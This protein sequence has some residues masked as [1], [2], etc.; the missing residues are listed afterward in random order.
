MTF[1]RSLL[2]SRPWLAPAAIAAIGVSCSIASF[3]VLDDAEEERIASVVE[4][5]TEWRSLDFQH[6]IS[7]AL[8]ALDSTAAFVASQATVDPDDLAKFAASARRAGD[9]VRAIAWAPHVGGADRAAFGSPIL[10]RAGDGTRAPAAPRDHYFPQ[11]AFAGFDGI[12]ADPGVD[13]GQDIA[14]RIAILR[15]IDDGRPRMAGASSPT[16][17]T[18]GAAML[19]AY[20]PIYEAD[21]TPASVTERRAAVRGVVAVL[22]R[23]DDVLAIA[24]RDSPDIRDIVEFRIRDHADG[25]PPVAVAHYDPDARRIVAAPIPA[26]AANP[27]G[28]VVERTVAMLGHDWD[29]E[30]HIA[31]ETIAGLVSLAPEGWMLAGLL[32]TGLLALFVRRQSRRTAAVEAVVAQRTAALARTNAALQVEMRER[33]ESQARYRDLVELSP[34]AIFVLSD[35]RLVYVNSATLR[36]YGASD[37]A[38]LIGRRTLDLVHPDDRDK[39]I[40]RRAAMAAGVH[41]VPPIELRYLRLDGT[42]VEVEAVASALTFD[43]KPAIQAIVRDI[44]GRRRIEAQLVQAQKMET[45]GQL[46]GGLAHD[47]NNLLAIVVGNLDLLDG[48]VANDAAAAELRAGALRGALRGAELVQRLLAFSRRQPL[49]PQVVDLHVVIGDIVPLLRRTLGEQIAI[50]AA[51][52]PDICPIKVDPAQLES[53]ILNLAVNARDAMSAGGRLVVDCANLSVDDSNTAAHADLAAGDYAVLSVRDTGA[54]MSAE[55][56][57][58]AFEPFFTTKPPGTASGLGLSMVY[59]FMKQS[60]GTVKIESTPGAGAT[61]RLY[62]PRSLSPRK[63]ADKPSPP[64]RRRAIGGER[65]LVVEDSP[66]VRLVALRVLADLG[67][68]PEEAADAAAALERFE[69]GDRFDLLFTDLV[70]P[71]T[72]DGLALAREARRRYP[73]LK[74]LLTSGFND[75]AGYRSDIDVLGAAWIAKPYR[76][77]EL[78]ARLRDMLDRPPAGGAPGRG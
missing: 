39:V 44:T 8:Q 47:F 30:F 17:P 36:L 71:G 67:Y 37:P 12:A 7:A 1:F 32:L 25:G 18:M 31:R 48:H 61:I 16:V 76:A 59:G 45:V 74:I 20:W 54:G 28:V 72:M 56:A 77:D 51:C 2:R 73:R 58:K 55:V 27:A 5:R 33:A 23:L 78:G 75:Q 70:M 11:A 68:Q 35:D 19:R 6:K 24:V 26:V 15:A 69:R 53:A 22:F 21:G 46:T 3:V 64:V 42:T 4:F 57:A 13:M 14:Q 65:I 63:A 50:D 43:G 49:M 10:D 9:P 60:G 52:G 38:Q 40:A 41:S 62:L 66:E 34:D 29:L